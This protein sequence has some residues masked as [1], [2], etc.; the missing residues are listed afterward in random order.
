[1]PRRPPDPPY[2]YKYI[3]EHNCP[4]LEGLSTK[5][6]FGEYQRSHDAN[7]EHWRVRGILQER[8]QKANEH[9]RKLEEENEELKAK[10]QIIHR[11]QF[12]AN[13]KVPKATDKN[14]GEGNKKKKRGAPKGHPG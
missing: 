10:I 8:V 13:K 12:K 11:R 14:D 1:M 6:A 7:I 4:H 9:I 5:W 2:N 3:Y